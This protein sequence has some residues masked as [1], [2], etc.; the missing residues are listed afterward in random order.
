LNARRDVL[1]PAPA[2]GSEAASSQKPHPLRV[3]IVTPRFVPETGGVEEHVRQIAGR[4]AASGVEATVL[5]TDVSGRLAPREES[6]GYTIIRVRAWRNEARIAP[7]VY[8]AVIESQC[9]LV[10]VQSYHTFVAPLAMLAAARA[11]IPYV[12]TFHAGG[13]SSR[14]RHRARPFQRRLLR[15]LLIRATGL[16]ALT[17]TEIESYA[18]ELRLS[19]GRFTLI[20]NGIEPAPNVPH[21]RS[22][23]SE[24]DRVEQRPAPLIASIGRLER[25]K[26][27]QRVLR[28]MPAILRAEP[29][30]RLWIA[31]NGPYG[32]TLRGLAAEL[33]VSDSVEFSAVPSTDRAGMIDRL[34]QVDVAILLSEF[35]TQPLAVLE[36]LALRRSVLVANTPGLSELADAGLA[37]SVR[38]EASPEEVAAAVLDLLRHPL[39]LPEPIKLPTW[40]ECADRLLSLYA[41][42]LGR[43]R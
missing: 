20:P 32:H 16:I 43:V 17:T 19:R 11:R 29:G 8:R 27:H 22:T 21:H 31:G 30:T 18:A 5:T 7:A 3:L 26:G 38:L 41:E 37:R 25:Y 10:H 34:A 36:A 24:P 23:Q 33:G 42:V 35:E 39:Q 15:P 6:N 12:L 40:D 14:L 13:H 28:A 9:D 4:F 2:P 1:P